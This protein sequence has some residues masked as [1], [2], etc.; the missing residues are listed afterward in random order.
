MSIAL[1]PL[2]DLVR[3]LFVLNAAAVFGAA[4]AAWLQQLV[5]LPL[6][7][8][9]GRGGFPRYQR[10]VRGASSLVFGPLL[11]G[12]LLTSILLVFTAHDP[13][14]T[15]F[16]WSGAGLALLVTA[17]TLTLLRRANR[18]LDRAFD[19]PSYRRVLVAGC[20]RAN[21]LGMHAALV[22][23]MLVR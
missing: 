13:V 2:E 6:A 23:V 10:G 7:R 20:L 11:V 18:R 12:D 15:I 17:T 22:A 3:I 4:A 19:V 8:R 1:P 14:T 5:V 16:V 9:V 21:L